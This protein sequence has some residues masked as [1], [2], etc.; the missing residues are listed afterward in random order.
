LVTTGRALAI[1]FFKTSQADELDRTL[2]RLTRATQMDKRQVLNENADD[3]EIMEQLQSSNHKSMVELARAI[4][5]VR[6]GFQ[7]R[8]IRRTPSSLGRDGKPILALQAPVIVLAFAM[9][10]EWEMTI[11]TQ[12]G[13]NDREKA[14]VSFF[15]DMTV[16]SSMLLK[17]QVL[18]ISL[19]IHQQN[20]YLSTRTGTQQP[21]LVLGHNSS[22]LKS[23]FIPF[24]DMADYEK[25][26]STKTK[27]AVELCLWH[28]TWTLA[29]ARSFFPTGGLVPVSDEDMPP[30]DGQELERGR[31]VIFT[32]FPSLIKP[33][34]LGLE[35]HGM[36]V[37]SIIGSSTPTERARVI[38]TFGTIHGPD[39]VIISTVGMTGIN[40]SAAHV[41]ILL[42]QMFSW[43]DK[44]QI[45]GRVNRGKQTRQVIVYDIIALQTGDVVLNAM[46]KDKKTMLDGFLRAGNHASGK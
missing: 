6:N 3:M 8:I 19:C 30:S 24:A 37:A 43:W 27:L 9:L 40:L 44:Q 10:T 41:M 42:D 29:G 4:G 22:S 7:G 33:I 13:K 16:N 28:C 46:A 21:E 45:I 2:T 39:V 17:R 34:I 38:N 26:A 11:I 32:E 23:E 36:K 31:V 15:V 20:F 1:N 12:L 5:E 18:H 25:R 14:A 35:L